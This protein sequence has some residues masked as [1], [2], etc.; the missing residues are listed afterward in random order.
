M[1]HAKTRIALVTELNEELANLH[2][3]HQRVLKAKSELGTA[4]AERAK[5]ASRVDAV[6]ARLRKLL[7]STP[8]AATTEGS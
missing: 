6:D 8:A 4:E 5:V 3:A 1:E 2:V 7:P